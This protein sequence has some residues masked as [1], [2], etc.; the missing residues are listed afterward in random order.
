MRKSVHLGTG[1]GAQLGLPVVELGQVCVVLGQRSRTLCLAFGKLGSQGV[2][3]GLAGCELG[4]G[5]LAK[6]ALDRLYLQGEHVP[7]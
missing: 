4:L 5:T 1:G 3:R 7:E 2:E 6:L